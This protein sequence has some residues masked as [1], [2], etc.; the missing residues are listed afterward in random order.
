ME[1]ISSIDCTEPNEALPEKINNY[2]FVII[3]PG[4]N[5]TCLVEG[6]IKNPERR[7]KIND[8]IMRVYETV[9]Q[10][11]F[12]NLDGN[13]LELVMAGEEFCANATRSAVFWATKGKQGE[14]K[15]KVSGVSERLKA[16]VSDDGEAFAQMPIYPDISK[17]T[18]DP[19]FPRNTIVEMEGI[20][21]YVNF[22][23]NEVANLTN[24]Q[25]KIKA[26]KIIR[27]KNLDRWSAAGVIYAQKENDV[28]SITPV[29]YVRDIDTLFLESA[30]GSGTAAL[31]L[32]LAS[33][34][35]S[36]I[37]EIPVIQPSGLPIKVS[38]VFENNRFGY[39]EI[40]GPIQM[41]GSGVLKENKNTTF[42][43]EKIISFTRLHKAF[44]DGLISLYQTIFSSFPYFEQFNREE[45]VSF[46]T[47]YVQNGLLF[48]AQKNKEIIGFGAALPLALQ[49]DIA[50]LVRENGCEPRD[51]WYMT[52]L[53]VAD[54]YR[55][56]GVA[57]GLVQ[58][59]LLCMQKGNK[60]IMRTSK[61]NTAS[62]CLYE[63]LG[64]EIVKNMTQHVEQ[65]RVDGS[66]KKDER[67]FLA[68]K[69]E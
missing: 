62:R 29:V 52:D 28:W 30:C 47:D 44:E 42:V 64:F 33:R 25:I 54:G 50:A 4:G 67:I 36:S 55:R 59:R 6:I 41:V 34:S 58:E 10:V 3:R 15:I 69:I 39:T 11:G 24:D 40:K 35:G 51:Y 46:F 27:E 2:R 48:I 26:R 18:T 56:Q 57:K 19:L 53:G 45:V 20:T 63:S 22:N 21:H 60:V 49:K 1:K 43:I 37:K 13:N 61:D 32:V 12:V 66:I 5:E 7:K 16:G 8:E 38:V 17:I 9:E 68:K 65:R 31:G 23:Y 14:V